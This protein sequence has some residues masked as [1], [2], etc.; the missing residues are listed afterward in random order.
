M[1]ENTLMSVQARRNHTPQRAP[2]ENSN[3]VSIYKPAAAACGLSVDLTPPAGC[4][5]SR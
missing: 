5:G 4:L 2:G 1:L 3:H